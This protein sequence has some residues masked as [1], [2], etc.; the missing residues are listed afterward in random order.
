[1]TVIQGSRS[2]ICIPDADKVAAIGDSFS[3]NDEITTDGR[4]NVLVVDDLFGSGASMDAACA[5]LRK[6]PRSERF[7]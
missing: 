3:V 1:M 4:W 7:T 6:Y 5:V 2:R